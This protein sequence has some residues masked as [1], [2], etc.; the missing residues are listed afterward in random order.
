MHDRTAQED[1]RRFEYIIPC[2]SALEAW[3]TQHC[4]Y[5]PFPLSSWAVDE[6]RG[7]PQ[8]HLFLF[9]VLALSAQARPQTARQ[10]GACMQLDGSSW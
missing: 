9:S 5:S 4:A 1:K 2:F 6:V 3:V 7:T 10:T 8:V